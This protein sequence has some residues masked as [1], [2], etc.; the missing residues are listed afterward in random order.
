MSAA[1]TDTMEFF[2][3]SPR[4]HQEKAVGLAVDTYST[5]T[6]GL[7]S[8]DC[9]VGKTI[10]VLSGYLAARG[11]DNASRL[12]ALTRTHSQSKV[13]ESE[14]EVL[15]SVKPDLTATT[16]VSRVHV[17]PIRHQMESLSSTG[18]MRACAQMIK[19]GSCHHYWNF[20]Q[21]NKAEGRIV[22]RD[23]LRE[24]V[25]DLLN[26]GVVTRE[27]VEERAA[28]EGVCPYEMM[29]WCA[30]SSRV[31][32]GPYSYIFRSRVR[33]ALLS[34][35]GISLPE[36]D[37][38]VDEAHNLPGHVLDAETSQLSNEDLRWLK[39]NHQLVTKETGLKWIREVI[40]FLWE[41]MMVNLDRMYNRSERVLDKWDVAPR[42]VKEDDLEILHSAGRPGLGDPENAGL[43]ET[44]LDRLIEFL[45]TSQRASKSE[46]WHVTLQDKKSWKE[47]APT[48]KSVL[49][50]QPLNSS[51]LTAPILRSA[52]SA[53]LMSGTLRPLDYYSRLLGVT[54]AVSEDL[55]SPYPRGT[56]L[57]LVDK[58]LNTKY[59]LRGPDL[60]R[61]LADR[62]SAALTTMPA[63]K[64][65]LIS[66]PSYKMLHEVMSYSIDTG[67]RETLVE[68][69]AER[70]E[71]LAE[72]ISD[73]PQAVFCVYGGK[74]SEGIDLV[75]D[76]TSMIDLIIGVGI[77]FSPPTS[78]QAAL[79]RWYDSRFG[80]GT[81]YYYAAVV[82][83]IRQVA[84]LVGRLRRS[85]TDT[86]VVVLLD[87]RF[88]KHLKVFGEE[89]VSD[90]WPYRDVE[91]LKLAISQ[92][93]KMQEGLTE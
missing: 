1:T 93:V 34:S 55:L 86:G 19:T 29:R 25:E 26:T 53:V 15:R 75:S 92:F 91:E 20:Y 81:G 13:F 57:V 54:G 35:L 76:G 38:L 48:S 49:M 65:A 59:Q 14:L 41:T 8:A 79:Q 51:G 52:R 28:D 33:D 72:A 82:P 22:I 36:V 84:Q 74:F 32:I 12:F 90:V 46:G 61:S 77:P 3:Y 42:F 85:P 44:P 9:G 63:N 60:W 45:F 5:K 78:Y 50:I 71:T 18:F 39:E 67:F 73:K 37:L 43:I 68:T 64:S 27:R 6:V 7:L 80:N 30:R 31:I 2:P 23:V 16:M 40:D 70:I 88:L 69:R 11:H 89:I 56:R 66:F 62:I 87:N 21:K 4:P 24:V 47:D 17:C 10:A 58:T 83:S